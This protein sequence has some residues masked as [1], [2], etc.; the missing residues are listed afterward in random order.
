MNVK[1]HIHTHRLYDKSTVQRKW[2]CA[3]E[4]QSHAAH[5]PYA[6][7]VSLENE[8]IVRLQ[9]QNAQQRILFPKLWDAVAMAA[10][11]AIAG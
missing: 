8:M 9:F 2:T 4:A 1:K 10:P 7:I 6:F 5:C 11:T 3:T